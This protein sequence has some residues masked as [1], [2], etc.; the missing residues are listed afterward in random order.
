[1]LDQSERETIE[2]AVAGNSDQLKSTKQ[3]LII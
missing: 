1:M 3:L 2:K